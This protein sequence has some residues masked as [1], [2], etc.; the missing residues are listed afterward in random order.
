MRRRGWSFQE[1]AG[2]HPGATSGT[3]RA[4]RRAAV[5]SGGRE[6]RAKRAA[7]VAATRTLAARVLSSPDIAHLILPQL[8]LR[9]FVALRCTCTE[10]RGATQRVC[11]D[12]IHI[13]VRASKLYVSPQFAEGLRLISEHQPH[14]GWLLEVRVR[15][16]WRWMRMRE[17][18]RCRSKEMEL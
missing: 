17:W 16:C 12:L 8:S 18:L 5:G 10:V 13:L 2:T 9:T 6:T 11:E 1:M 15:L 4:R 14:F 7:T 3:P